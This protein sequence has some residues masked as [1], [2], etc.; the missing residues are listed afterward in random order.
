MNINY[1]YADYSIMVINNLFSEIE[2]REILDESNYIYKYVG[3]ESPE[4]TGTDFYDNGLP[5]RKSSSIFLDELVTQKGRYFSKI[6]KILDNKLSGNHLIDEYIKI[7]PFN[8][9]IRN[10][11]FHHTLL[12][13]YEESDHYDFHKDNNVFSI[14]HIIYEEPKSFSGGDLIF[15]IN[16][17][18][19]LIPIKNNLSIIFP[20]AYEHKVTKIS[21]NYSNSDK[22]MGR[23]SFV[24]FLNIFP[25]RRDDII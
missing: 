2:I 14:I 10:T 3:L 15:K 13:Y 17:K 18:E 23:F 11:N 21:M 6:L 7:N 24:Q 25:N 12:N 5:K 4:K 19:I 16:N 8:S 9:I 22:M 20:A 1:D